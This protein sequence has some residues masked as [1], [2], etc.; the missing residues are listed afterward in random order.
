MIPKNSF[1]LPIKP[2]PRISIQPCSRMNLVCYREVFNDLKL[3]G[4]HRDD[5]DGLTLIEFL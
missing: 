3:V 5:L 2:L 1:A 4:R